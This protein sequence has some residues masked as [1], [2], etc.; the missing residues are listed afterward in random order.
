MK[1]FD[2]IIFSV[3]LYYV[4][5]GFITQVKVDELICEKS[6]ETSFY[7]YITMKQ[8]YIL[9]KKQYNPFIF[10][11]SD[12]PGLA[13]YIKKGEKKGSIYFLKKEGSIH[14]EMNFIKGT[15]LQQTTQEYYKHQPNLRADNYYSYVHGHIYSF[16]Y[17]GPCENCLKSY[18]HLSKYF[19]NVKFDI[20]FVHAYYDTN[21]KLELSQSIYDLR[22]KYEKC[23]S[24]FYEM[25][26]NI[27]NFK[28]IS[29]VDFNEKLETYI[30]N[31][32]PFYVINNF[33]DCIFL[34][35]KIE[36]LNSNIKFHQLKLDISTYYFYEDLSQM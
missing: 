7:D 34:E 26:Q 25:I 32:T 18:I 5:S 4:L 14:S 23:Q 6:C 1:V 12:N 31:Q 10:P 20:F 15:L 29:F 36:N 13:T 17:L 9:P 33:N 8:T 27:K 21:L 35:Y 3:I 19:A 11:L 28:K 2:V 16:T 30:S 24:S 22:D